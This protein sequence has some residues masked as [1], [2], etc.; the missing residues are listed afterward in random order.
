MSKILEKDVNIFYESYLK[1]FE[2]L[3]ENF[4][5]APVI[6]GLDW[7]KP[8]E[9]MCDASGTALGVILGQKRNKMF[10]LI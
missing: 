5:S 7:G 6:I 8:F 1:Y 3:K 2:F 9:V 10:H 4:I